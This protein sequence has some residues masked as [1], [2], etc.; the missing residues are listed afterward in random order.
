MT[1]EYSSKIA[2]FDHYLFQ[3]L[4]EDFQKLHQWNTN[5]VFFSL[6]EQTFYELK[7]SHSIHK[8]IQLLG[9]CDDLHSK[10]EGLKKIQEPLFKVL[11][12]SNPKSD[13]AIQVVRT[14]ILYSSSILLDELSDLSE[15]AP[16]QLSQSEK[17]YQ[18]LLGIDNSSTE[19]SSSKE[20]S[21]IIEE[22]SNYFLEKIVEVNGFDWAFSLVKISLNQLENNHFLKKASKSLLKQEH[23][24]EREF[25][26]LL[27]Q[28]LW[29]DIQ[30]CT[31]TPDN[32]QKEVIN[33]LKKM[34]RYAA[35]HSFI[36]GIAYIG[37]ILLVISYQYKEK[38]GESIL[39]I[40]GGKWPS[41]LI[42]SSLLCSTPY[43]QLNIEEQGKLFTQL[44]NLPETTLEEYAKLSELERSN[45]RN[46]FIKYIIQYLP[47]S[48]PNSEPTYQPILNIFY[49]LAGFTTNQILQRVILQELGYFGYS[50]SMNSY[51]TDSSPS[52]LFNRFQQEARSYHSNLLYS[53]PNLL[54]A[55]IFS[56]GQQTN[57]Y[58]MNLLMDFLSEKLFYEY[59]IDINAINMLC[60][61]L[62]GFYLP[63]IDGTLQ[64]NS[65]A[66]ENIIDVLI[67]SNHP[68]K[69]T[70]SL[71]QKI[72]EKIFNFI[73]WEIASPQLRLLAALIVVAAKES[74]NVRWSYETLLSITGMKLISLPIDDRFVQFIIDQEIS[75]VSESKQF[76]FA[77]LQ[78]MTS[79]GIFNSQVSHATATGTD[80]GENEGYHWLLGQHFFER[81][82]SLASNPEYLIN[83]SRFMIHLDSLK[84]QCNEIAPY[85]KNF[86]ISMLQKGDKR[87]IIFTFQQGLLE[88]LRINFSRDNGNSEQ[89]TEFQ[90]QRILFWGKIFYPSNEEDEFNATLF[91]DLVAFVYTSGYSLDSLVQIQQSS[92]FN[93]KESLSKLHKKGYNWM[94]LL[95][96][97][98]WKPEL[99]VAMDSDKT[100]LSTLELLQEFGKELESKPVA[101]A[102][103][104]HFFS[105]Y[106]TSS[107]SELLISDKQK[108]LLNRH[109]LAIGKKLEPI[110]KTLHR[111]YYSFST[112]N[113][114]ILETAT[115]DFHP[116]QN[117]ELLS[118]IYNQLPGY[119]H[120]PIENNDSKNEQNDDISIE[121][122]PSVNEETIIKLI[123]YL[124]L[125]SVPS[126]V[127]G[128]EE[129]IQNF[130]KLLAMKNEI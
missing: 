34:L 123:D 18:D 78:L 99:P 28:I 129:E 4:H 91:N 63:S 101:V 81:L 85:L 118:A 92:S 13:H 27:K 38:C 10:F 7:F 110:C 115:G 111:L 72:G 65:K 73:R 112:W 59:Y 68:H 128:I 108:E 43:F 75:E 70:S 22:I 120:I 33:P 3:R 57:I 125:P 130:K 119:F 29:K 116:E 24:S 104:L 127:S 46:E 35:E 67:K 16:K 107:N 41:K 90:N 114:S 93:N 102:Y 1:Y 126:K 121:F 98:I 11:L 54:S 19:Y 124:P 113:K 56:L 49:Q 8:D 87:E 82:E 48:N 45:H 50:I 64:N 2:R 17:V 94:V 30:N 83:T 15:H 12:D 61:L 6:Y 89:I 80:I 25:I 117:I 51:F 69:S 103:W 100:S 36:S 26:L 58:N 40:S 106:F 42:C 71:N 77:I 79:V 96:L 37:N 60:F 21:N 20:E 97:L 74:M 95:G 88:S 52:V 84:A 32:I 9:S 55:F 23:A 86:F 76:E 5:E 66:L 109:F 31:L 14:L 53:F 62:C 39:S 105:L 44:Y 122:K 47:P